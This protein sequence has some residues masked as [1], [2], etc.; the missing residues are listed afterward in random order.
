MKTS[1]PI[2]ILVVVV[3][4]AGCANRRPVVV[5]E[6][7]PAPVPWAPAGTN[8]TL[9]VY[10]AFDPNAHFN[11]LP[12]TQRYTNYKILSA[13]GKLLQMVDNNEGGLPVTPQE[14]VLPA[15]EYRVIAEAN[16][17]SMVT[18]PVL[19]R[20]NQ[21]TAVHLESCASW[22]NKAILVGSNAVYLP[23]GEIVGWRARPKNFV[24]P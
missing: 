12:Y 20:P 24:R 17:Y 11:D 21:L 9:V 14:I 16:A 10:S 1:L 8:G 4:V 2:T 13:R 18:V 23:D 19:I 15:G 7:G 22:P 6:V 5:D 3:L